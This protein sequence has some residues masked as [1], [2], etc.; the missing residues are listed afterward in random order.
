MSVPMRQKAYQAFGDLEIEIPG[1]APDEVTGYRRS[2]DLDTGIA[3]VEFT[4]GG[5][6]YRREVFASYPANAIVVR[7]TA[8]K[9]APEVTAKL[10]QRTQPRST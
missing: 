3:A 6:T 1:G 10:K 2:L 4:L 8:S 9:P 7:L 5:V